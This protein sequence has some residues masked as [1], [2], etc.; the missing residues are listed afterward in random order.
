M[1]WIA[2]SK[3]QHSKAGGIAEYSH[4][5][6]KVE[7]GGDLFELPKIFLAKTGID[8]KLERSDS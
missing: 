4:P 6:G 2:S 7:R 3:I 5:G 8:R 1:P